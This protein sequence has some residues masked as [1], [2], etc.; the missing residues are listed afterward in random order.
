MAFALTDL[1][2]SYELSSEGTLSIGG[3]V[4]G[5]FKSGSLSFQPQVLTGRTTDDAVYCR[6][7]IAFD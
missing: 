7:F 5:G 4:L 1:T 2:N 6:S 3:E